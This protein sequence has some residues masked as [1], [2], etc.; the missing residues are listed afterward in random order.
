MRKRMEIIMNFKQ[1]FCNHIWKETK[2]DLLR[3]EYKMPLDVLRTY[4]YW[5]SYQECLFCGK[6]RIK[7][8]HDWNY[9]STE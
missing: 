3:K 8:E 9:T 5:A 1:L 4:T 7:Q 6:K 2:K